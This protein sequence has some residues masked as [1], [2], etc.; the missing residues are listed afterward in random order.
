MTRPPGSG[1]EQL[2]S[3]VLYYV[4]V[5]EHY[6]LAEPVEGEEEYWRRLEEARA[7]AERVLREDYEGEGEVVVVEDGEEL[8]EELLEDPLAARGLGEAEEYRVL[9]SHVVTV[10]GNDAAEE[11]LTVLTAL[12]E[13]VEGPGRGGG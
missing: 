4:E 11:A 3:H 1:V 8:H 12:V 9:R 7:L 13:A 6:D 10:E 5:H 2:P